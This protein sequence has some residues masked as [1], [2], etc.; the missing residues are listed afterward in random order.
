MVVV[1]DMG[2]VEEKQRNKVN[3]FSYPVQYKFVVLSLCNLCGKTV[4][5]I[6]LH[7]RTVYVVAKEYVLFS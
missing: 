1:G 6:D 3:F 2:S 5:R 7:K 4:Y